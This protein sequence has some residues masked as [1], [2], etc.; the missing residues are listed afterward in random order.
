MFQDYCNRVCNLFHYCIVELHCNND[1]KYV[2]LKFRDFC[3]MKGIR[4]GITVPYCP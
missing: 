3:R 4:M 1:T 2:N